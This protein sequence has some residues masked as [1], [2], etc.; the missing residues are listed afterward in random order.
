VASRG[1]TRQ[2][3]VRYV[4]VELGSKT[5]VG[6][7][8]KHLLVEYHGCDRQ[9]LNDRAKLRALMV[10]AAEA[11]GATVVAEVFHDYRPQGVTGVVVIEESHFALHTWPE[12]GYAAVDFY[13]CG[14]CLP[15]R[16]AETLRLAFG[17]ERIE[18]LLVHRGIDASGAS[19][20]I[21]SANP[22]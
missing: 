2:T 19:I 21:D 6:T 8:A 10:R 22:S 3:R 1:I 13:T 14:D 7:R 11:A 16:A 4:G 5:L 17:A 20:A 9:L 18:T 15:E 12:C